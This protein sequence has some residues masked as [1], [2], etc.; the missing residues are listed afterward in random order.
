MSR[1]KASGEGGQFDNNSVMEIPETAPVSGLGTNPRPSASISRAE[2][3][4]QWSRK[5]D[6]RGREYFFNI[7]TGQ[8]QSKKPDSLKKYTCRR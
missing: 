6:K 5:R 3:A 8:S 4:K 1:F 7:I 2:E